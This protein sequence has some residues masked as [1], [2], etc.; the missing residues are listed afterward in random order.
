MSDLMRMHDEDKDGSIQETEIESAFR[1]A[2]IEEKCVEMAGVAK[3]H[4]ETNHDH[5]NDGIRRCYEVDKVRVEQGGRQAKKAKVTKEEAEEEKKR[6]K[7]E[8]IEKVL[9][10]RQE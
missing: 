1:E 3:R 10:E 5:N 7:K 6:E 8:A 2:G 9:R 4:L